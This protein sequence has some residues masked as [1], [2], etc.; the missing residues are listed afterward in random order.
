MFYR[1]LLLLTIVLFTVCCC[2]QSPEQMPG[3]SLPGNFDRVPTQSPFLSTITGSVH[4]MS[5]HPVNNVRIEITDVENGRSLGLTYT[6]AN[7][8]FEMDNVPS[9]DLEL[10]ATAGTV[11][12]RSRL[13]AAS[14]RQLNVRL[15]INGPVA[16]NQSAVSVT[17]LNIPGKARHLL[18]KAE[19]AV[20]LARLDE[21]FGFVQKALVCYPNYAKALILRGVLN[22][23][24]GDNKDAE[25]DLEKAVELDY[26]DSTGVIALA[27]LYNNEGQFDRAAQTLDHGISLNPNS[28]QAHLEMARSQL[29]K[30]DYTA[31]LRSLDRA[32]AITP[33]SVTLLPLYR[34]QALIGLKDYDGAISQLETYL[35]KS[36]NDPNSTQA[37]S[38]LAKLK[39]FTAS[40][41]K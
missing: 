27:S 36:P 29:G 4:D 24:K 7:G 8:N 31:A 41:Q 5:G 35:T 18:E 22:M 1:P 16:G 3:M 40:A 28:W 14:D 39:E 21:A 38:M 9:G 10:V 30:K 11:E 23:Q 33:P 13:D 25:P 37:R 34:A 15:P 32:A 12:A 6:S 19:Q 20:R 17:Q 26:T 2:A